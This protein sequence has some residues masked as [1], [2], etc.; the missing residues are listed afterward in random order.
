MYGP[1]GKPKYDIDWDHD[2][3]QGV[4]HRHDWEDGRRGAGYPV[5]PSETVGGKK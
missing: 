3:G 5:D 1:D 4:P 2:H